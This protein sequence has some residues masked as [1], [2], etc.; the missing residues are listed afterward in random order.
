MAGAESNAKLDRPERDQAPSQGPEQKRSRQRTETVLSPTQLAK[1]AELRYEKRWPRNRIAAEFSKRGGGT[2]DETNV[3]RWD[4]QARG[5]GVITFSIDPSFALV[6]ARNKDLQDDL[7]KT[8]DLD[9]IHVFDVNKEILED[10]RGSDLHTILANRAGARLSEAVLGGSSIFVAGGRTVIRIARMISR[11]HPTQKHI[12]VDPLSGRNWSG[13]WQMEG[14]DE[15]ERPLDAD[16]AAVILASAYA[17]PGTRFS[18]IGHPLYVEA[19]TQVA[20]IMREHCAFLPGGKWNWNI[21]ER[22][23]KVAICGIGILHPLS[24]H[25]IM[26]FLE[27]H[28][29]RYGVE[30]PEQ[31][32][33][34]IR[35]GTIGEITLP[36]KQDK[37]APYL[38]RIAV[39]LIDAIKFARERRLGYIGDVANR[40]FPCL[41]LPSVLDPG[42]LPKKKDYKELAKKLDVLNRRAIVM[43][44]SH[45]RDASTWIT[46]GGKLKLPAIWTIG[47]SGHIERLT[48]RDHDVR[49][50][51]SS[52]ITDSETAEV[53]R[54]E[55]EI[56][57]E[58]SQGV[59]KWYIDLVSVLFSG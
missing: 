40:L 28:L 24:G 20:P 43:E 45:L 44:W 3:N 30:S 26:R 55:L 19:S 53:L 14:D 25:R 18:Q 12:R 15:L 39:E 5:L 16:D 36:R 34:I 10:Q 35:D 22:R 41:P 48:S 31:L 23:A 9:E 50:I 47:I 13:Q 57:A 38:S 17:Q 33:S 56:F 21:P 51:M 32:D 27:T 7:L 49:S 4:D 46:A 29:Q 37:S 2:Y 59:R 52:L 1:V 6:G 58:A 11:K 8:L 54:R 42:A